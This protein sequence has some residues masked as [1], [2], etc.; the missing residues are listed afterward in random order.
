[1]VE[2]IGQV[3]GGKCMKAFVSEEEEFIGNAAFDR[4]PVETDEGGGDVLPGLGG[5]EN[6]GS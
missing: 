5:R 6:P 4:E 1:M 3:V 2:K